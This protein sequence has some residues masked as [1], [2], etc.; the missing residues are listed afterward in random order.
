MGYDRANSTN[1]PSPARAKFGAT[2]GVV[3][4]RGPFEAGVFVGSFQ[5]SSTILSLPTASGV[6]KMSFAV[7]NSISPNDV[8]G[9]SDYRMGQLSMRVGLY[10][11][12]FLY[13]PHRAPTTGSWI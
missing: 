4:A 11:F 9:R 13:V 1:C 3:I 7:C 2:G 10:H 12:L 5:R 6:P 8:G